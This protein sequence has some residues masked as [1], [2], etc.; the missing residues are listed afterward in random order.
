M[1]IV[2]LEDRRSLADG[3]SHALDVQM[4]ARTGR[5]FTVVLVGEDS[6]EANIRHLAALAQI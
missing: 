3:K 2:P 6:L 4:L 1:L 5:R